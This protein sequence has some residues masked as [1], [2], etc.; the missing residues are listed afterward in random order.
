MVRLKEQFFMVVDFYFPQF[1]S[2]HGSI[3]RN[4]LRKQRR[5]ATYFNP[6]MVRLK[7]QPIH[8]PSSIVSQ[9]QSQHGSI[10]RRLRV[11]EMVSLFLF[12]SQHG[13]IKS[14]KPSPNLFPV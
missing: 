14:S 2:Q 8:V 3:K 1:Q 7:A 10:K 12:Q 13:S 11:A 6:N 4:R 5:K 9:F